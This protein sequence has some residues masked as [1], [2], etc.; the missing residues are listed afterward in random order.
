MNASTR[1]FFLVLL[2]LSTA[3]FASPSLAAEKAKPAASKPAPAASP[4]PTLEGDAER[5][6]V[7]N[8]KEK[9]WARGDESELGVVQNRLYSKERRFQLG[10]F[11]G[12]VA[13][14]PFLSI[15]NLGVSFGYNFGEYLGIHL[16]SWKDYTN[17]SSARE[18]LEEGGKKANTNEPSSYYGGE[19]DWSILYG[20][21]SLLGKKIIYYDMHLSAGLGF[22]KTESG[23]NFTQGIGIGQ[24]FYLNKFMTFKIDYRLQRYN[25]VILEKEI[26]TKLGQ[27]QGTRSNF[28]NVIT[29]GLTFLIGKSG[30]DTA[31]QAA[32][33]A[34][35]NP[36]APK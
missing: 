6:N 5:L 22:T 21:L 16:L 18:K 17:G 23:T 25:E 28:S 4:V 26:T 9:Y 13:S 20:K 29:I 31:E 24:Q 1:W 8:I 35:T 2:V 15:K 3:A 36:G 33:A 14:D 30:N 34:A 12:I 10:L 19:L 27:P 7:E 11:G 32:A